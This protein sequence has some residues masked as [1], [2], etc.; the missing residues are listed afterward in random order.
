[1]GWFSASKPEQPNAASRQDRQ[2]CWE[3][4]DA[5]FTCLD[6]VGVVK[7]GEEGSVCAKQKVKYDENCA[8]S[9]VCDSIALHAISSCE[10]LTDY[11]LNILT[12]DV[13]LLIGRRTASR[14]RILRRRM[15][16]GLDHSWPVSFFHCMYPLRF[17]DRTIWSDIQWSLLFLWAPTHLSSSCPVWTLSVNIPLH[18]INHISTHSLI[19]RVLSPI[20]SQT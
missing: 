9:W 18:L 15:H 10:I 11:R 2:N 8:K 1:M 7:A 12:N 4:R 13:S 14:K 17:V 3:S 6:S 20:S 16:Q 5:Y 19:D